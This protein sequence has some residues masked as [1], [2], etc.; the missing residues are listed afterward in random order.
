[1]VVPA[2]AQADEWWRLMR[3][4]MAADQAGEYGQSLA[5]YHKATEVSDSFEADDERR[6][7]T[8]NALAK[9]QDVLGNFADAEVGYR[10]ALRTAEQA[11]GKSSQVYTLVLANLATMYA[12]TRQYPRGE[13][14]A[15]EVLALVSGMNPPNELQLAMARSCLATIIDLAGKHDEAA[16]LAYLSLPVLERYPDA[17]TQT[18]GTLNTMG[19]ALFAE[20]QYAESERSFL[21]ALTIAELHGGSEHPL[22]TRILGNLATIELRDG[23]REEARERLRRA[24]GIAKTHLGV[25][26]PMYGV[27]LAQYAGYLRVA[28]EKSQAKAL[29]AQSSQILKENGRRNGIGALVDVTALKK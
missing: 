7:Y 21:R 26:H 1:M 20:R 8:W 11:R 6:A 29:A 2:F 19:S 27:L 13:R 16:G 10:R 15:R 22:L 18:I 4:G 14:I 28:G 3:A 25:E 9:T 12:E 17:W 23:R 24:L 5:L